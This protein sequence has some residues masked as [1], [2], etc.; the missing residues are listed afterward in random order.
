MN[1]HTGAFKI[2]ALPE[3]FSPRHL[4]AIVDGKL[5]DGDKVLLE[6]EEIN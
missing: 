1:S 4:Q 5:K 6:V 3:H 2:L